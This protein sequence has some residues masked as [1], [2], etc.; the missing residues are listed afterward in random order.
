VLSSLK[1]VRVKKV[2]I[3]IVPLSETNRFCFSL[4]LLPPSGA[5]LTAVPDRVQRS[6]RETPPDGKRTATISF[7]GLRYG[8]KSSRRTVCQPIGFRRS[9]GLRACSPAQSGGLVASMMTLPPTLC[10]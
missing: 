9:K 1:K 6:L 7:P 4:L 5:S 3:S 2:R 10:Q 8:R